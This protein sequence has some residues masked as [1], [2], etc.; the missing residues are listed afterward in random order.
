M[1]IGG[2]LR[3]LTRWQAAGDAVV[4]ALSSVMV[5]FAKANLIGDLTMT[6][7]MMTLRSLVEKARTQTS[8][9]R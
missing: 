2:C 9:A 1:R 4:I 7:E 8:C 6:D 5:G 3:E